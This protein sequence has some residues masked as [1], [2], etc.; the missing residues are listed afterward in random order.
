ME[1][2]DEVSAMVKMLPRQSCS[3]GGMERATTERSDLIHVVQNGANDCRTTSESLRWLIDCRDRRFRF[4][5][6]LRTERRL[7]GAIWF[8]GSVAPLIFGVYGWL[9]TLVRLFER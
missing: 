7:N 1:D 2:D 8:S 9:L 4:M 5:W 6:L 3:D